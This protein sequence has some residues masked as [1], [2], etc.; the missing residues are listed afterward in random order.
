[1]SKFQKISILGT[2]SKLSKK[3]RKAIIM[4]FKG[5]KNLEEIVKELKIT[6]RS[7]YNWKKDPEFI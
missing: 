1:M 7:I 3:Q 2:F 6:E 5:D 4:L